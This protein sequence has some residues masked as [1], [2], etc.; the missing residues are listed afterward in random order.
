MK[1]EPRRGIWGWRQGI[2]A[3]RER[4]RKK[5]DVSLSSSFPENR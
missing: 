5:K 2:G 1:M 4:E 3:K